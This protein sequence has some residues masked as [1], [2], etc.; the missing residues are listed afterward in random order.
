MSFKVLKGGTPQPTLKFAIVL[1][2]LDT[3]L[4]GV[5][6]K[7]QIE[8]VIPTQIGLVRISCNMEVVTKYKM[9][10][11][12]YRRVVSICL[13]LFSYIAAITI[14][15]RNCAREILVLQKSNVIHYWKLKFKVSQLNSVKF[16]RHTYMKSSTCQ[17][18]KSYCEYHSKIR[19]HSWQHLLPLDGHLEKLTQGNI[20][21]EPTNMELFF[22]YKNTKI[23]TYP[24]GIFSRVGV[25]KHPDVE[26][27]SS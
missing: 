7:P 26:P 9:P 15:R 19:W 14:F 18:C 2:L 12:V 16:I 27:H 3:C 17:T 20:C 21:N 6:L 8:V 4:Q 24:F 10:F 11:S 23:V 22:Q 13:N 1:R 25:S 5:C